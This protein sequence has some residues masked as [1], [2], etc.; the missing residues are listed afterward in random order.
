MPN[1]IKYIADNVGSLKTRDRLTSNPRKSSNHDEEGTSD[2]SNGS[3]TSP[4][5]FYL[6][7]SE[8][9]VYFM[10]FGIKFEILPFETTSAGATTDTNLTLDIDDHTVTHPNTP[11]PTQTETLTHTGSVSPNPH[12]HQII[13][14]VYN[15]PASIEGLQIYLAGYNITAYLE[16]QYPSDFPN[17]GNGWAPGLYPNNVLKDKFSLTIAAEAANIPSTIF[18]G[19]NLLPLEFTVNPSDPSNPGL[20]RVR[21]YK[22][23]QYPELGR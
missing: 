15:I 10:R 21:I 19:D 8:D 23:I 3:R 18:N 13:A 5:R 17:A 9:L 1:V 2:V 16:A 6:S 4:A 20:F 7:L 11:H 12:G 22:Y 14:G